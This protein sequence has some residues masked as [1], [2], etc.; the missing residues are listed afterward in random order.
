MK[1]MP[2]RRKKVLRGARRPGCMCSKRAD[3]LSVSTGAQPDLDAPGI[4]WL[5]WT[6]L[7]PDVRSQGVGRMMVD[8]MLTILRANN[9]R[10]VFIATSDYMEDGE[11]VYLDARRFYESLGA[12]LELLQ[13]DYHQ[14]GEARYV[15]G[16]SVEQTATASSPG[17]GPG[18]LCGRAGIESNWFRTATT[19]PSWSSANCR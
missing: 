15:Y 17:R 7:H 8:E 16:L 11:D 10:K 12:E 13:R 6:Y 1:M 3:R 19:A 2:T 5:S 4:A 9:V 18:C 14:R